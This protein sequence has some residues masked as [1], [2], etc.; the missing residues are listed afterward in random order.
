MGK[1]FTVKAYQVLSFPA[2]PVYE[3]WLC[4][5]IGVNFSGKTFV[6]IAKF[7]KALKLAPYIR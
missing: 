2:S 4:T 7:V 5:V 3:R 6:E 1:T